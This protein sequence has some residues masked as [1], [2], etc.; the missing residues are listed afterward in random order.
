MQCPHCHQEHPDQAVFCPLTGQPLQPA[1]EPAELKA[2]LVELQEQLDN[3]PDELPDE[4]AEKPSEKLK[5][6][7]KQELVEEGLE[8]LLK[9]QPPLEPPV[10]TPP[11]SLPAI[12]SS[13]PP[14]AAGGM[15]PSA[16]AGL[17][18]SFFPILFAGLL[19]GG[20]VTMVLGSYLFFFWRGG[21]SERWGR[22]QPQAERPA[23]IP[24]P[25]GVGYFRRKEA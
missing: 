15:L 22:N 23:A 3:Q 4:G 24:L 14:P 20:L 21:V 17:G 9:N 13:L 18:A 10:P 16:G 12:A 5:K 1:A 2:E 7:L 19:A 8:Q 25:V 11:G 6:E